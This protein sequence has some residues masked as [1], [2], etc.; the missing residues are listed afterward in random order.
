[1]FSVEGAGR[2]GRSDRSAKVLQRRE[3]RQIE[4]RAYALLG[5][6]EIR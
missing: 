6:L 3:G 5:G 1:M 2:K 4:R